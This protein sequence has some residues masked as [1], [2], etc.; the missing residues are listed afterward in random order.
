M[1]R[2]SLYD[3]A[4]LDPTAIFFLIVQLI[5]LFG[6]LKPSLWTL[7]RNVRTTQTSSITITAAAATTTITTTNT[8]TTL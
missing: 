5:Y 1:L 7:R 2:T 3:T 6:L 4:Y 8:I